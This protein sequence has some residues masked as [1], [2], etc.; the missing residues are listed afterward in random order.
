MSSLVQTQQAVGIKYRC[1]RK[2]IDDKL[3]GLIEG[4]FLWLIITTPTKD[5]GRT[6]NA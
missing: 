3:V 2:V 4:S 1:L 6:N 5:I